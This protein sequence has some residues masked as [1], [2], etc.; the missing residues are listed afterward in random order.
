[1]LQSSSPI[2]VISCSL[3]KCS[4]LLFFF[5]N[6]FYWFMDVFFYLLQSSL[7]R[8]IPEFVVS[9]IKVYIP[10]PTD[11]L[12]R[13]GYPHH[14]T[15]ETAPVIYHS[16]CLLRRPLWFMITWLGTQSRWMDNDNNGR[17][18]KEERKREKKKNKCTVRWGEL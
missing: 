15:F 17:E 13:R 2:F 8:T 6:F 14:R 4:F 3:C 5:L 18:R 11:N 7:L 12:R 16:L 10:Y 9:L 1:M